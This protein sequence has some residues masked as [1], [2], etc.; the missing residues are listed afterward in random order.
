[1]IKR[2]GQTGA[3]RAAEEAEIAR[4]IVREITSE[5]RV[6]QRQICIIIHELAMNLE[7]HDAMMQITS[8]VRYLCDDM[9]LI[10]KVDDVGV[11]G[12]GDNG[13]SGG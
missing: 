11:T 9:F 4:E 6:S 3:E 13:T 12:G 10:D 2:Y 8:L 1:M 5:L 7:R